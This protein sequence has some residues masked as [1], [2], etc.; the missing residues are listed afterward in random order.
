MLIDKMS[1]DTQNYVDV[2]GLEKL[3]YAAKNNAPAALKEVAKQFQ[4]YL[5]QMALKSMSEA[6]KAMSGGLFASDE[7]DFYND[8]YAKQLSL[9]MSKQDLG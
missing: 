2:Q 4:A 9:E 5:F 8:L 7:M 6:N 3:R 1:Y